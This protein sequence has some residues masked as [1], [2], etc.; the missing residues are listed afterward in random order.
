MSASQTAALPSDGARQSPRGLSEPPCDT[1]GPLGIADRL[2]WA[3]PKKRWTNTTSQSPDGRQV[4]RA[5]P[6]GREAR[7]P[8]ATRRRRAQACWARNAILDGR[9][10]KRSV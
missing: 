6:L 8:A 5:A 7:R 9:K 1:F 3:N 10:P 2:N 4:V